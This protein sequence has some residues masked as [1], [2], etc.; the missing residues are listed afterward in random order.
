[1]IL[2]LFLI[3]T[4][5]SLLIFGIILLAKSYFSKSLTKNRFLIHEG[6]LGGGAIF[7]AGILMVFFYSLEPISSRVQLELSNRKN[8]NESRLPSL[9]DSIPVSD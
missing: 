5:L 9:N 1:M 7:I 2:K 4:S 8:I 3:L 6:Y